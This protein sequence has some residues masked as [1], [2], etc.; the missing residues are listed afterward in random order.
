MANYG[1]ELRIKADIERKRKVEKAMKFA[2]R[3]KK[4]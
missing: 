3:M 2:E 4:V 1:G